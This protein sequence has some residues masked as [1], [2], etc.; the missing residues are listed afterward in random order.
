MILIIYKHK[1]SQKIRPA[2][3]YRFPVLGPP[4]QSQ[5]WWKGVS[6]T[7]RLRKNKNSQKRGNV[8]KWAFL[9][10]AISF[11]IKIGICK[12]FITFLLIQWKKCW[13]NVIYSLIFFLP[14]DFCRF[15]VVIRIFLPH[16][17]G[18]WPPPSKNFISQI[19]SITFFFLS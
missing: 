8:L 10:S 12:L 16:H 5:N 6:S 11:L 4:K 3:V 17:N 14:F 7:Y 2:G 13:F 15:C 19:L 9:S 18:Q 1:T